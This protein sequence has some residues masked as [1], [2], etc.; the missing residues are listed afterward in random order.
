[1]HLL[2]VELYV[3]D[4]LHCKHKPVKFATLIQLTGPFKQVLLPGLYKPLLQDL[5]G[6]H[7]PFSKTLGIW[8]GH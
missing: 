1:M 4:V 6:V 3:K 5:R 7:T 8:I 2:F